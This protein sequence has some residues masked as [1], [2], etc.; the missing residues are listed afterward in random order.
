MTTVATTLAEA[1][2]QLA[3]DAALLNQITRLP[4]NVSPILATAGGA[5]GTAV[6]V[7]RLIGTG[8]NYEH[9]ARGK[10]TP[11]GRHALIYYR[12]NNHGSSD[13]DA[14]VTLQQIESAGTIA[15]DGQIGGGNTTATLPYSTQLIFQTY[16]NESSRQ[17]TVTGLKDVDGVP[18]ASSEV[19]QL[20][21]RGKS[22]TVN[23]WFE[24]SLSIDAP[25]AGEISVGLRE[26]P[27]SMIFV[28][29][30]NGALSFVNE[31][32]LVDGLT[33]LTD[34]GYQGGLAYTRT[35]KFVAFA[36]K[37]TINGAA[38]TYRWVNDQ[39]GEVDGWSEPSLVLF[40]GSG[41]IGG[42]R[43]VFYSEIFTRQDG[44]L[45][46]LLQGGRYIW[47]AV[48]T[49]EG[50]NWTC[51]VLVEMAELTADRLK[52][53][54]SSVASSTFTVAG[55]FTSVMPVGRKFPVDASSASVH[56]GV[57]TV[58]SSSYGAG[59]T[60]IEVS[61]T[62]N[63]D[64]PSGYINLSGVVA[65]NTGTN[66]FTIGGDHVSALTAGQIVPLNGSAANDQLYTIASRALNGDG[67]NTDVVVAET[68][69]SSSVS[70][71]F[72]NGT[73]GEIGIGLIDDLTAIL[74]CRSNNAGRNLGDQF[75]TRD[76]GTTATYVGRIMNNK[77]SGGVSHYL[78]VSRV[79]GR[80]IV[81]WYYHNRSDDGTNEPWSIAY[82]TADA[83]ALLTSANV[84]MPE[85]VI[86]STVT[87]MAVSGSSDVNTS[88][89]YRRHGYPF[90]VPN[91]N[92]DTDTVY[93]TI[94]TSNTTAKLYSVVV[95]PELQQYSGGKI[96]IASVSLDG[97]A[98]N[99]VFPQQL[100]GFSDLFV[101]AFI[102]EPNAG[103][104]A[105]RV[106]EDNGAS[107]LSTSE[108]ESFG[109]AGS[110]GSYMGLNNASITGGVQ[111]AGFAW[112]SHCN[113]NDRKTV[114][115][116]MGGMNNSSTSGGTVT[117]RRAAAGR[118]NRL[119][120][121]N[122]GGGNITGTVELWGTVDR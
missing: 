41:T 71:R 70:G 11:D 66:T 101:E 6:G 51:T 38:G 7:A 43:P 99:Y 119:Q 20:A 60:T 117:T 87:A 120:L 59:N 13:S 103:V 47:S 52:M 55:D 54:A 68:V 109:G 18:T 29:T 31:K 88:G 3:A 4:I 50:A 53:T 15:L 69:T 89:T 81:K 106:S 100:D 108:Y 118:L 95:R 91:A 111:A 45:W 36:L 122:T 12:G 113:D 78:T 1:A 112:L 79:S 27:S 44:A 72:Q 48:S 90:V 105:L 8:T 19:V 46:T 37:S 35:H 42:I 32:A 85:R 56:N 2:E 17:I 80:A 74:V 57:Y 104:N 96:L 110:S 73:I 92:G 62:V 63:S 84:W 77:I 49:D 65:V 58:V 98:D 40:N 64:T 26:A 102:T 93:F 82:R 22:F 24:V 114:C 28:M 5:N 34:Q 21:N 121:T 76:G 16:T 33:N 75:V 14:L 61:E 115:R 39:D 116:A 107:F 23:R 83:L 30:K 67:K 94:E 86:C 97:T 10:A 9:F 25:T